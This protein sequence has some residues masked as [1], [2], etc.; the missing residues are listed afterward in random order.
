VGGLASLAVAAAWAV[1]MG[2]SP[3]APPRQA[4]GDPLTRAE[5]TRFEE[6]TRYD[7]V[8]R[9]LNAVAADS[10]L[11]HLTS[12]G[13]S[14]EGR[15]LPLA[16]VGRLGDARPG[17]VR[18]SG[19]LRVYIQANVHAGEVEGK[20]AMLAMVRDLAG[21]AHP[22]WLESMVLLVA[23]IYNADGN[24]RVSLSNRTLQD[25]PIGGVGTRTNAQGLNINRDYIKLETPE[26]RA[27]VALLEAYDPHVMLDLHTTNGSEHA[28]HLTFET[29]NNPAVDPRLT[30]FARDV[31]MPAVSSAVRSAEGW[32]F[33]AYGVVSG[34]RPNR[35]WATV[36]DLPRYSHNYWGLRNRFGILSETYSYLP[37]ADRIHTASRFVEEVLT[38]AGAN[39][40][41]I[42]A[43]TAE[44][45]ATSLPG[46]RLSLRSRLR[47]S[48]A[49]VE[50]LMGATTD[51]I[52]PNTGRAMRRRLDVRTPE[53]MWELAAF[54][55]AEDERVPSA[56]Y[57]PSSLTSVVERLRAHGL[58][59][60]RVDRAATI[61]LEEF[62]IAT[63]EVTAQPYE[64]HR[65]R[66][67]TGHYEQVARSVEAGTWRVPMDQPL[68]RLAF[69]LLEPRSADGLL[70]WNVLDD[71][72]EGT[73]PY[74]ILR[75]RD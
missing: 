7:E 56:Y 30:D 28:Y 44:A 54:E 64:N 63:S 13:E 20:E 57:I 53:L 1:S 8:L 74:P 70:T 48:P 71:A 66:T 32:A 39:A 62:R 47:R 36:E 27:M 14:A 6:T 35:E 15:A 31:W 69:T 34:D 5:R 40:A 37:F 19:L 4:P 67:V 12:F 9:F 50:I 11:V 45:D 24:E 26:A 29:P 42:L 59:L 55:P 33:R 72:L 25:G 49:Q 65:E 21:G 52:N 58:R 38:F 46:S 3:Q 61:E 41:R 51:D 73:G 23:P 75:S 18:A 17:T 16:V 43:M 10:D 2:A 68:A 22:E 60:E